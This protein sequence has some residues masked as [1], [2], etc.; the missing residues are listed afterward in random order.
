MSERIVKFSDISGKEIKEAKEQAVIIIEFPDKRRGRFHLD[1]TVDEA[2][3][4]AAK[5]TK[6]IETA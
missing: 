2:G 5:G 6:I 3:E 4:L 1:A